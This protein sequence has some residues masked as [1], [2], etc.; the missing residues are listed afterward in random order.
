VVHTS[1]VTM[2]CP[3]ADAE[4]VKRLLAAVNERLPDS[5]D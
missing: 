5:Y 2:I 1:D 3:V 4:G